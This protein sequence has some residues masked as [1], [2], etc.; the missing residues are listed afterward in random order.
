M[1]REFL[2]DIEEVIDLLD[3]ANSYLEEE[4]KLKCVKLLENRIT[5]E[6]VCTLYSASVKFNCPELEDN[7]FEFAIKKLNDIRNTEA[8]EQMNGEYCKRLF[9]KFIDYKAFE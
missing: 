7:C 3:L 1:H 6:N 8:F 2:K 5:V 4:L 9:A